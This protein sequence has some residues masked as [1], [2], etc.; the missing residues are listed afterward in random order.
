MRTLKHTP[1]HLRQYEYKPRPEAPVVLADPR[2]ILSALYGDTYVGPHGH[3]THK[4]AFEARRAK[5]TLAGKP[6]PA[7]RSMKRQAWPVYESESTI[8]TRLAAQESSI[9][10]IESLETE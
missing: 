4:E 1:K 2:L 10:T 8:T 9:D 7:R 6:E 3:V 5:R